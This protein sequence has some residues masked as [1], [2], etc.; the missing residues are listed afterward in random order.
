MIPFR[1]RYALALL[2][3]LAAFAGVAQERADSVA[4][5]FASMWSHY[6]TPLTSPGMSADSERLRAYTDGFRK[7]LR[8]SI[9]ETYVQG[10]YEG[11][12]LASRLRTL[13]GLGLDV[14]SRRLTTALARIFGGGKP[15]MAPLDA[16]AYITS[17]I[18]VE[19]RPQAPSAEEQQAFLDEVAARS[20]VER[21]PS[22]LLFEIVEPGTGESP[23]AD[24]TAL[25]TYTGTFTDGREFDSA[26]A[27]TPIELP[28]N[29][30]VDG[31]AEGLRKMRKGGTYRLFIPPALAYGST[32]V[33]DVIPPGAVII[34]EVKL[35][36]VLHRQ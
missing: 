21:T 26:G 34:F 16:E 5:A 7:G 1:R 22:G 29:G 9:N 23:G 27:D 13:R 12:Q 19:V 31:M 4:E 15:L 33:G 8:D 2:M 25:V 36:D 18:D 10:Y 24:D 30:V 11:V 3:S 20:G 6:L 28:L 35:I 14:D 32:G 17:L